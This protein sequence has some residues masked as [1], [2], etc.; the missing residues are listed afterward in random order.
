MLLEIYKVEK[1]R[2]ME[3]CVCQKHRSATDKHMAAQRHGNT[4]MPETF[5]T[6]PILGLFAKSLA[7]RWDSVALVRQRYKIVDH[8]VCR[9]NDARQ[10]KQLSMIFLCGDRV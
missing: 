7:L 6:T 2:M 5:R 1:L 10:G 4:N 9:N 8:N 3:Q